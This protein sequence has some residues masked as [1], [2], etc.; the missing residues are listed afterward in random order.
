LYIYVEEIRVSGTGKVCCKVKHSVG[1]IILE[2]PVQVVVVSDI[3]GCYFYAAAMD[4]SQYRILTFM[5]Q[6]YNVSSVV[7]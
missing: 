5:S 4:R 6:C 1:T 2:Q 7:D 3:T